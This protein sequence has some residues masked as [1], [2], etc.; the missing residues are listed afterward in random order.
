MQEELS[1]HQKEGEVMEEPTHK[2][3]SS[4]ITIE[5]FQFWLSKCCKKKMSIKLEEVKFAYLCY[6]R[7]HTW[8][9]VYQ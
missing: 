3:E 7:N 2:I 6:L 9:H 1:A 5:L 4:R 8:Y